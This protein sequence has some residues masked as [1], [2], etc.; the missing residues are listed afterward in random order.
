VWCVSIKYITALEGIIARAQV[1]GLKEKGF[2]SIMVGYL[3]T[4]V[5]MNGSR[6]PYIGYD[7]VIHGGCQ[8]CLDHH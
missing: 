6:K 5:W 1:R 3:C 2:I 4:Q 7:E 8:S